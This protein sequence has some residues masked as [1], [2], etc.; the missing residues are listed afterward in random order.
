M[1]NGIVPEMMQTS[2]ARI[3]RRLA[4]ATLAGALLA[5]MPGWTPAWAQRNTQCETAFGICATPPAPPGSL[6]FCSV[7]GRQDA[8]K[9]IVPLGLGP[10]G[11]NAVSPTCRSFSGLCQVAPSAVGSFCSCNG[12]SG[13]IIPQ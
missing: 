6:C 13:Q 5:G 9:V 3:A 4:L 7:Q 1:A 2:A 11:P 8:G 10:G 12:E